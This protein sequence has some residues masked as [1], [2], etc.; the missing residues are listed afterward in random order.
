M[1]SHFVKMDI[2]DLLQLYTPA[3]LFE[4]TCGRRAAIALQMAGLSGNATATSVAWQPQSTFRGTW[5]ILSACLATLLVCTWT[6]VHLNNP[7]PGRSKE[8]PG[9]SSVG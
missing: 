4:K 3:R 2:D 8:Q 7:A 5:G 6:A 1:P 9:G